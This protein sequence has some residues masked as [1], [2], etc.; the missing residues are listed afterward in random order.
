M[1]LAQLP[2]VCT[3]NWVIL[4]PPLAPIWSV[5]A[6]NQGE[7]CLLGC[8]KPKPRVFYSARSEPAQVLRG[9]QV[10]ALSHHESCTSEKPADLARR[11]KSMTQVNDM[12]CDT[13]KSL[14]LTFTV[15]T[16][17]F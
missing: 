2:L 7:K 3:Q 8:L 6:P 13:A 17:A 4:M 15:R 16:I 1:D 5:H 9:R 11:T 14:L 10:A 12:T